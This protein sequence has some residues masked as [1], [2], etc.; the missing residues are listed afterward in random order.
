M[1]YR[2]L[3]N[4]DIK[5][6]VVGMGTWT[7]AG[8]FTWGPQEESD[9][10]ATIHAALEAGITFFDT[11]ELYGDGRSEEILGRALRGRRN[12]AVIASKVSEQHLAPAD[13]RQACH[14]SLRRLQTDSIDLYQIHWPNREV[15][16]PDTWSTL[17]QLQ[18]EGKIRAIGISNFGPGDLADL[19][20]IGQP[21][22]NQV[23]YSLLFRAV[24]FA[25]APAC[26]NANIEHSLSCP[27]NAEN[28][29]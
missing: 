22:T 18:Q 16:W 9:S 11:A 7:L 1:R 4:T 15:P 24:E 3:P 14:N 6:S 21:V 8:D 5:I 12:Q 2:Y 19:T 27:V 23:P 25:I 13:L 28:R 29:H 10:I 26:H 17:Q 20:N